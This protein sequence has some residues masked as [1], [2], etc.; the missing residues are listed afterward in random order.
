MADANLYAVGLL[1]RPGAE[2][3]PEPL[4]GAYVSVFCGGDDPTMAAWAAIQAIEAMGFSVP[5]S[6]TKVDVMR[7]AQWA[8]F[9]EAQWPGIN[10]A[11]QDEVYERLSQHRAI[12]GPF[13]GFTGG[14]NL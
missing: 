6:P 14:A 10:V 2:K 3:L 9:A 11:T 5:E 13:G 8:Q 7:A 1:V 4:T 12:I